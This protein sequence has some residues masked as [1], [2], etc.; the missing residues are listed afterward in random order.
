MKLSFSILLIFALSYSVKSQVLSL[1]SSQA[2]KVLQA[3]NDLKLFKSLD[4]INRAQIETLNESIELYSISLETCEKQADNYE[5]IILAT[6]EELIQT[7][8]AL[9]TESRRAKLFKVGLILIPI[10]FVFGLVI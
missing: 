4:T 1:D 2:V 9:R 3:F 6:D 8:N 7:K 5:L 10:A